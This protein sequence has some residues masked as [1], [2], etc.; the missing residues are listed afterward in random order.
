MTVTP[1][2]YV[3]PQTELRLKGEGMP[4]AETGDIVMDTQT[5]LKPKSQQPSGDL[6]VKFNITFPR[7]ILPQHREAM[8]EALQMN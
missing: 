2:E 3:T 4:Y 1:T 6:I 8:V 7:Q 5:L